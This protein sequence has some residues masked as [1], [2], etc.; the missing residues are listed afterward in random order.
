MEA[1]ER[2]IL[3]AGHTVAHALEV[4]T[5]FRLLHGE[6]LSVGLVAE[7]RLGEALDLTAGGTAARLSEALERYDLPI[8]LPPM[9]TPESVAQAA[10]TDKK[11][12]GG[13]LRFS[14]LENIGKMYRT[15]T[16]NWTVTVSE[17]DLISSLRDVP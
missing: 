15:K 8:D 2:A 16:G 14:L 13:R 6:A 10:R 1:G 12:R 17:R 9:V 4:A 5:D 11:N 7:A 3:N